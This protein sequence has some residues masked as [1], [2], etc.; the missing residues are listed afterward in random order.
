MVKPLSIAAAVLFLAAR[1][2]A[3]QSAQD[4][5]R[6]SLQ[7]LLNIE[8]TTV[9]RVPEPTR[10]VPAAIFVITGDDIRRSGATSIPQALRLVPGLQVARISAGTWAIGTR[11]FADRLA[12][13][14]LVM[15]DGRAVYSPL[16]AG[17]YW[18]SQDTLLEDVD[19]IEVIRGPGGTLWGAN[20]VNGI[21]NIITKSANDT[22]GLFV[23]AGGG[24]QDRAF[25]SVRYGGTSGASA[26]RGYV[27]AF[28]RAPQFHADG[29]DYDTWHAAQ[30]GFRADWALASGRQL[31]LQGD[32]YDGRLG[33]RPTL[34]SY[35]P[36]YTTSLNVEAPIAGGN[37]LGRYVSAPGARDSFQ[38]Q[39][40]YDRTSRDEMPVGERRDTADV[41]FQHTLRRWTR[42]T[43]T[44][45]A[46]YRLSSGLIAAVAPSALLPARRTD[47]LVTAFA[48]DELALVPSRWQVTFG[49]K[50]EHNQ[51]SGVEVQPTLRS[52]WTLG[53]AHSVWAGVTRAVRT[54]SRVETDYT[55]TSLV[56]P[57]TPTFVRLLPNPSFES[58]RLVAYEAGY[59]YHP[60]APIYA[61]ASAFFNDLSHALSTEL[62]TAFV[63]AGPPQRLILPVDFGNGLHGNSQ[64]VEL[65]ADYRPQPWWR[66]T[67]NYSYLFVS[68]SPY[69]G[70]H[71]VSQQRHYEGA[72]PRHQVQAGTSFEARGWS[73]DGLFRRIADLPASAVAAYNTADAR[74]ARRL[75][76]RVE[77]ALVGQDLLDPHHLEWPS[78]S[79]ANIEVRRSLYGQIVW[80]R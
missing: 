72:I 11:G 75:G 39:A 71:D 28:D 16:F 55:T 52:L 35:A 58:E 78:G 3:A 9:S 27:K 26:Y 49:S 60:A 38:V 29:N 74:V 4:L 59:R 64:G 56:S 51:Y 77:L 20:A 30:G 21:I 67:G 17:T 65:T 68:M 45:G 66:L 18:E 8:V 10:D 6:M 62:L 13:S 73:I 33:E 61:T 23:K 79:G 70:S 24:S 44:W 36:P 69:P 46:G 40:Y 7:D 37:V 31:T 2:A 14:M 50:I 32:A 53:A 76:P 47:Q 5:K 12:R 63:E 1:P 57:A 42:H 41:D 48:Q 54:P 25:T 19:R 15:I 34:V 43:L 22:Q 80:R